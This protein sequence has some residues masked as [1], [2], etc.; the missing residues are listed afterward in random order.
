LQIVVPRCVSTSCH[1][2]RNDN[3]LHS[4]PWEI[5]H[6][7]RRF[8]TKLDLVVASLLFR[9]AL[10]VLSSSRWLVRY[11][12]LK[13]YIATCRLPLIN[14]AESR[15][16]AWYNLISTLCAMEC[17]MVAARAAQRSHQVLFGRDAGVSR[18]GRHACPI[19][20]HW[21]VRITA[22]WTMVA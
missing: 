17:C 21:N 8:K 1:P 5:A 19:R 13:T 16:I 15:A 14:T 6:D 12:R 7:E 9:L 20:N 22:G 18:I 2:G 11:R 4:L 3:G 10:E